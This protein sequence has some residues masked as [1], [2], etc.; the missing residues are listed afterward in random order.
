[1]PDQSVCVKCSKENEIDETYKTVKLIH[2]ELFVS[3]N[4]DSLATQISKN[5]EARKKTSG[6]LWDAGKLC[7]AAGL[8][9]AILWLAGKL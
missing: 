2:D 1:M 3:T 8:P 6:R 4:G 5:T 7:I 9:I